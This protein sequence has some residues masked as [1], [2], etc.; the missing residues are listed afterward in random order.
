M[1]MRGKELFNYFFILMALALF[2]SACG[3]Q[4]KTTS[5]DFNSS[6]RCSG[7]NAKCFNGDLDTS[8]NTDTD[9]DTGTT[10]ECFNPV[11]NLNEGVLATFFGPNVSIQNREGPATA[12]VFVSGSGSSLAYS[13]RLEYEDDFGLRTYSS[14]DSAS[15]TEYLS[16]DT[17][18]S[19]T[20]LIFMDNVG[21]VQLIGSENNDGLIEMEIKF[22]NLPS[23]YQKNSDG[24]Y[25]LDAN[26]NRIPTSASADY[27]TQ[28]ECLNS[29]N[30]DAKTTAN[31]NCAATFRFPRSFWRAGWW[32]QSFSSLQL[33]NLL[34]MVR[35]Y[36]DDT[37][38]SEFD[39]PEINIINGNI[40]TFLMNPLE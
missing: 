22:A 15:N 9:T 7:D 35:Q 4:S 24:S 38:S 32:G 30:G 14:S 5:N 37:F 8:D 19:N 27:D 23:Y 26:N 16:T 25:T 21:F 33:S 17:S 2:A 13:F 34:T 3:N 12:C 31:E 1:F 6:S 39:S 29:T 11:E 18:P 20:E 28:L 10:R 40:G 36:T